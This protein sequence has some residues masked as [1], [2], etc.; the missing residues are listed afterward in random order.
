[1]YALDKLTRS[2]AD[3]SVPVWCRYA[4]C[5]KRRPLE[6]VWAGLHDAGA[7][8]IVQTATGETPSEADQHAA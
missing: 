1:M 5:A 7:F 6:R 3:P 8:R 2:K 4:L